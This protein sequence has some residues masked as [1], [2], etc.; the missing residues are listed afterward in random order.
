MEYRFDF[1][2]QLPDLPIAFDFEEVADLFERKVFAPNAARDPVGRVHVKKLQDVKYK[3]S[4]RCVTTYE[5]MVGRPDRAPERTIGV[6]EFT[7]DGVIPRL[8]TADDRL[9]WLSKATDLNEMQQLFS[10]LPALAGYG[11]AIKLWEIFPV[12]YKP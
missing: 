11:D 9:S 5:L 10:E 7:P 12:R 8:F 4:E 2:D 3:P 6:L 1:D